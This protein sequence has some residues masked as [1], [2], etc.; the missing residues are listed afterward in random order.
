MIILLII[1]AI[2]AFVFASYISINEYQ[3]K[4]ERI[5]RD[6][7]LIPWNET[8]HPYVRIDYYDKDNNILY[9]RNIGFGI[10]NGTVKL[11]I[12][13]ATSPACDLVY[14]ESGQTANCSNVVCTPGQILKVVGP[15][16][17]HTIVC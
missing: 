9:I 12:D 16:Y 10:V 17:N 15:Y 11:Y 3:K 8:S 7:D 4:K 2:I 5:Q 13:D 14:I 1:L 6:E